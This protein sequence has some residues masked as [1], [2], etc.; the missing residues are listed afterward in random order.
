V[1]FTI[2][3]NST[4]TW[5]WQTGA[6]VHDV[7]VTNVTPYKTIVGQGYDVNVSVTVENQGN[8]AETI[9]LTVYANTTSVGSQNF[10]LSAGDSINVIFTWNTTSFAK[11]N[12]T[13]SANAEPVPDETDTLDN[14]CTDG[15]VFVTFPGDVTGDKWADMQDISIIIDAFMSSPDHPR[16]NPVCD[17][18]ND[19]SVD[20]ADISIAIDHFMTP[21]P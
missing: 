3:Q 16:W 12:Y 6:L 17:L 13:I 15:V 19:L 20:M 7:A 1:T 8:Y 11:G 2:T 21:D 9:S 10:T 4:I 14:N 18:N 5:N